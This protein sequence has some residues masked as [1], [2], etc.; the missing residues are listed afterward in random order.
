MADVDVVDES[1]DDD[2]LPKEYYVVK[3]IDCPNCSQKFTTVLPRAQRIRLKKSH[4][5]LRPEYENTEPLFYEVSF[6]PHCGYARL[7][8]QFDKL[9]D[10]RRKLYKMEIGSK[11]RKQ[12]NIVKID[13]DTAILRFKYALLTAKAMDFPASE[14][15]VLYYKMSW[16]K[17]I[18][19]DNQGYVDDCRNAYKWFEK[20]MAEEDFP[21]LSIDADTAEYLMAM[22]AKEIG[23]YGAS[24]KHCSKIIVAKGIND[25]LKERARDL[26]DEIS[27][28]KGVNIEELEN[29]NA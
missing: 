20:T 5:N 4:Q 13:V 19:E 6:C 15:A 17:Q 16:L 12:E 23:E 24:L 9:T 7:K 18:K 27:K 28:I 21:V 26:K 3:E 8:S 10:L 25:R 11:F 14:F 29:A 22:F 2:T 1:I